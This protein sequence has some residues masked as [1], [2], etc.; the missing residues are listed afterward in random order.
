VPHEVADFPGREPQ[1]VE[2]AHVASASK[3]FLNAALDK[4]TYVRKARLSC[5]GGLQSG[6]VH[7]WLGHAMYSY[8]VKVRATAYLWGSSGISAPLS[9]PLLLIVRNDLW[10]DPIEIGSEN[11]SSSRGLGTLQPGECWTV[12]LQGLRGVFAKCATD[13][14]V[15]CTLI[16][17]QGTSA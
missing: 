6:A 17:P 15:T 4:I 16:T 10:G 2:C 11:L 14:T 7:F 1:H 3:R 13:S 8:S 5:M 9:V 12:P